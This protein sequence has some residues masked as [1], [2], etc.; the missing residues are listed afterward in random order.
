MKLDDLPENNLFCPL[1]WIGANIM[2]SGTFSYCCV[3][4]QSNEELKVNG[5]LKEQ[6]IQQARNNA[7]SNKLRKDLI[8]G[9][10]HS[11]CRDCWN[12]ENQNI[13]SLRQHYHNQWFKDTGYADTFELN[14]D[15]TLD[16]ENIIYWDVRQTNLCNMNCIMCGPDYSS[17]W[18]KDIL[19]SQNKPV[20][21]G[22]VIDAVEVSKD[23]ILEIIKNNIDKTYKFNFA[24]GEP[25]V[26]PMHW[27][28][29]EEL[30]ERKLFNVELAYNTNL[31]KLDYKGKNIIDYW[32]K[33]NIVYV[34]CSIDAVGK[35][36]EIIRTGTIW[37]KVDKNFRILDKE[38]SKAKALNVTTSNMSIGGLRDTIEWAKSFKWNN[39]YGTLIANNL[40]YHPEWLSI[41]VLPKNVKEVVWKEIKEPL[42]SLEN[43]RHLKQIE[44][45][46]WKE[47]DKDRLERLS[48][49][50]VK[51]IHWIGYIRNSDPDS[52]VLTGCPE[53]WNWY[54]QYKTKFK[55][56]TKEQAEAL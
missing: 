51:H 39:E 30:V 48:L 52:L 26:S 14:S 47:I 41:N 40:V 50:F 24:G 17:L 56:L 18:N 45:E 53:L 32:K 31:L 27:A 20:L 49:R 29:L 22:G 33:F 11:S 42:A 54:D 38:L 3:Q 15:G 13:P 19:K 12:L 43:K 23:N 28:I 55:A 21:K 1:T 16:N 2:P 4:D 25:L 37:D 7:W 44:A 35:R 34:G 9:I 8:N 10:Q 46:L 5:N 36:A 6:T